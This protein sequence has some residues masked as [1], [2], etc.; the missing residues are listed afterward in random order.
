M[1]CP[2]RCGARVWYGPCTPAPK[3][4]AGQHAGQ[5]VH[6]RG[7][8]VALVP[9]IGRMMPSI[10]AGGI[11]GRRARRVDRPAERDRLALLPGEVDLAARDAGVRDVEHH[12]R[13]ACRR[14]RPTTTDWC[15]RS[16]CGRPTAPSP[17]RRWSTGTRRSPRA[18]RHQRVVHAPCRNGW[19]CARD[20]AD[21][22]RLRAADRV[23]H[24]A[25]GQHLAHASCRRSPRSRRHRR[26]TPAAATGLHDAGLEARRGTRPGAARRATDGPTDRPA[27][28]CRRRAAHRLRACRRGRRR[29]REVEQWSGAIFMESS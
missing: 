18:R 27:P 10:A 28:A 16:S 7:D 14:A 29:R 13:D 8:R 21:A 25:V 1:I 15:R 22:V 6:H 17:G 9:A 11:G 5:H 3:G 2:R 19:S 24:G 23:L 12:R 26:R 20:R 4:A